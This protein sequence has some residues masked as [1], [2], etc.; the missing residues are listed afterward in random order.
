MPRMKPIEPYH[1][2]HKGIVR[3]LRYGKMSHEERAAASRLRNALYVLANNRAPT[4]KAWEELS[5]AT[6]ELESV[7]QPS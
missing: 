1:T 3:H 4:P 6:V 7:R 2:M 5:A